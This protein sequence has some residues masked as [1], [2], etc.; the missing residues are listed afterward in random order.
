M[1][2]KERL[3]TLAMLAMLTISASTVW[4]GQGLPRLES[5]GNEPL[6]STDRA[7]LATWA[8]AQPEVKAHLGSSRVRLLRGGAGSVKSETGEEFR[9]A[10]LYYRNYDSGVVNQI[11]IHLETG[12]IDLVDR[13]DL[14]Q[15]NPEEFQAALAIIGQDR[16][17]GSLLSDPNINVTGG[18]YERSQVAA[19]PCAKDVCLLI[20]LMNAGHG[21]GWAHRV[22]V[23][24]SREAVANADFRG[25]TEEGQ[26]V[27]LTEGVN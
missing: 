13:T 21:N 8:L 5:L 12:E 19:D 1:R 20:E 9:K 27:P 7:A 23:N 15:P 18:F 16:R 24:M 6:T 25:P 4:A 10:L 14:V 11:G 26:I 2:A 22:V 3:A 17:L